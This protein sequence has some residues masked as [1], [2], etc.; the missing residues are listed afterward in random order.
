MTV[1]ELEQ[2]KL[3][4]LLSEY[5]RNGYNVHLHP[6]ANE[7]PA[8]LR[9]FAPDLVAISPNDH[10]V[11][12]VNAAASATDAEK[13]KSL[14]EAVD[15]ESGWRLEVAFVSQ[16]VAPDVPAQEQLVAADGINRLLKSAE[17][18][19]VIGQIEAAV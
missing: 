2:R 15:R 12:E 19:F 18:L 8:F 3:A 1:N 16:P 17:E 10:V 13:I 7:L 5:E 14:A 4:E 11:I 9:D 6:A